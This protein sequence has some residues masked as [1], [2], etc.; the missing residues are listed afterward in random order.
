[1]DKSQYI[2]I[3]NFRCFKELEV[4]GFKRVNLIGGKNNT[5]KTS[6]LEALLLYFYPLPIAAISLKQNRKESHRI[7]PK[8]SI[9]EWNSLFYNQNTENNICIRG[10]FEYL[11]EQTIKISVTQSVQLQ[12][13]EEEAKFGNNIHSP[14]PIVNLEIEKKIN[15]QNSIK[16]S[17][18]Y[19][20]NYSDNY[21]DN[22]YYSIT[23]I[24]S[25]FI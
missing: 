1:M 13:F 6:L 11:N 16:Y 10:C 3:Q 17:S 20:D 14:I 15:E 23:F 18:N 19:L 24:P 4:N 22:Y 12:L 9:N 5:G 25:S 8:F 2:K 21:S 7:T